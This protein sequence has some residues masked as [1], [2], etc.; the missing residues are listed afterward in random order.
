MAGARQPQ[1]VPFRMVAVEELPSEW[2][3]AATAHEMASLARQM[4]AIAVEGHVV[5]LLPEIEEVMGWVDWAALEPSLGCVGYCVQ[6]AEIWQVGA[7]PGA[8]DQILHS[9]AT[10]GRPGFASLW[11]VFSP[12]ND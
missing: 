7:P 8:R 2:R 11:R 12:V 4:G 3:H 5:F 1:H 9:L 10:H 6:N